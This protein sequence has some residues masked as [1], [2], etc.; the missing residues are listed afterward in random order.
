M[1]PPMIVKAYPPK[2]EVKQLFSSER[3][4]VEIEG[5]VK[6]ELRQLWKEYIIANKK[7]YLSLHEDVV[8]PN[9]L[10][11][12][13]HRL[14]LE[15]YQ[16]VHFLTEIQKQL[17]YLKQVSLVVHDRFTTGKTVSKI[18]DKEVTR[19]G[20]YFNL[21]AGF[22]EEIASHIESKKA[23]K[24]DEALLSKLRKHVLGLES[25]LTYY[26]DLLNKI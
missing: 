11:L 3:L 26:A 1:P 22:T 5:E 10:K 13:F 21:F 16:F 19:L 25:Q 17:E 2:I 4:A 20:E 24:I 15:S 18:F 23:R 7:H 6:E 14:K 12:K 8:N 9:I